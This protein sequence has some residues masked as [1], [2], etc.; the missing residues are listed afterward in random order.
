[1]DRND[2][3]SIND[4]LFIER[5][6]GSLAVINPKKG[7]GVCVLRGI[8]LQ[9]FCLCQR[10]MRTI[11]ELTSLLAVSPEEIQTMISYF[12][13][14]GIIE[15]IDNRDITY[16]QHPK[17]KSKK[18]AIWFHITNEC[19][20]CCPYCYICKDNEVMSWDIARKI[21]DK[22]IKNCIT[23]EFDNLTIKFAGGEPLLRFEFLKEVVNYAKLR[24]VNTALII[25]F[26]LITNGTLITQ[27]IA[28]FLQKEKFG[29]AISMDGIGE[30]N[31]IT[32]IFPDNSGSYNL[33]KTGITNLQN[34]GISPSILT[35]ISDVNVGGLIDLA[36][37]CINR[38]LRFSFTPVRAESKDWSLRNELFCEALDSCYDYMESMLL[39]GLQV[40]HL[41]E[42]INLNRKPV[43]KPCAIGENSI[44]VDHRGNLSLCQVDI[45]KNTLCNI[46]NA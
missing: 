12:R 45:G 4:C 39:R 44:I 35:V 28:E 29:V 24:T 33:I 8:A 36:K 26:V 17:I 25:K 46:N 2:T 38:K 6:E 31:D 42:N 41:F 15:L 22:S 43:K 1:M 9:L 16:R 19:N 3:I 13:N 21:L 7:F 37:F 32:R 14:A 18:T 11:P 30:Y 34:E 40:R 20:L 10:G 5:I 27:D 23:N